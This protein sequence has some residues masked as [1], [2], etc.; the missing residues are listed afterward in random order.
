MPY[1]LI[2]HKVQDYARWKPVFDEHIGA[3]QDGGSQGGFLFRNAKDPNEVL[4]LLKWETVEEGRRF[5][6]S[7][8]LR[9]VMARAGVEGD[10]QITFLEEAGQLTA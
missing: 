8:G 1:C 4:V 3:R 10:P 5:T 6:E 9:E 2:R 7:E